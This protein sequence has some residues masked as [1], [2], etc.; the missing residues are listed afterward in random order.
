MAWLAPWIIDH[1]LIALVAVSCLPLGMR[2]LRRVAAM[3]SE[4]RRPD[5][6][7]GVRAVVVLALLGAAFAAWQAPAPRFLYAFVISVPA[8][9]LALT[10]YSRARLT[11]AEPRFGSH[12]ALAFVATS[13]VVGG[14]YAVASQK[15]NLWSALRRGA[16]VVSITRADLVV[17]SV[18][19]LPQRLFRWRVNDVDVL[20]PVPRPIADTLDYRSVI[21]LNSPLEKCSAAPIPC[22]PYLP[23]S[24]VRLRRPAKGLAGGFVREPRPDLARGSARCIGEVSLTD[25]LSP[26]RELVLTADH[27]RCGDDRR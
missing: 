3:R 5:G 13:V 22:T 15:L 17:P 14:A 11:P 26:S 4:P 8:L 1:P 6:I 10:M 27:A 24:D 2:V 19:A 18:P 21:A 7:D 20:T 23:G 25:G 16:P 12:G 9:A